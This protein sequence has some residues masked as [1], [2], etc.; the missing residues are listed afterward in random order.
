[1]DTQVD[2]SPWAPIFAAFLCLILP[3]SWVIAGV[4]AAVIHEWFHILA[5]YLC[6]SRICSLRVGIHGAVME[7]S[8]M[9]VRQQLFCIL[10]GPAG[11]LLL[12]LT[13]EYFPRFALCG[14]IQGFYNLLPLY[15]LD[16]GRGLRCMMEWWFPPE[17]ADQICKWT[18]I[19]VIILLLCL[20][21]WGAFAVQLGMAP[22]ILFL[23]M[24]SKV[25]HGKISC[26][27]G[28]MRVQ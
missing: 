11:S 10:A 28:D 13:G 27:E 22:V 24:I 5:V 20:S 16:G 8:I 21:F 19:S 17:I 7:T 12:V 9:S 23:L 1:M 6:G 25:W 18:E 14:F 15:P 26:K 2:I 4:A 3:V